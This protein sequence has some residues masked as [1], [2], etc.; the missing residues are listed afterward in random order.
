[1]E[2]HWYHDHIQVSNPHPFYAFDLSVY[3]PA[4]AFYHADT[5]NERTHKLVRNKTKHLSKRIHNFINS[6]R[7]LLAMIKRLTKELKKGQIVP[8]AGFYQLS[9]LKIFHLI[10]FCVSWL[11][12]G[13]LSQD[14]AVESWVDFH[15]LRSVVMQQLVR[16]P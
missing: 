4:S 6:K 12:I 7:D 14:N 15:L 10:V 9:L 2:N 3:T 13:Y 11:A 1:M 16:Q 8:G 5:N